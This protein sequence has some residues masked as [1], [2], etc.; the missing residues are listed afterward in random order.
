MALF[1]QPRKLLTSS[2]LPFEMSQRGDSGTNQTSSTANTEGTE[3]ITIRL[4]HDL[5]QRENH[6]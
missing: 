6:R 2:S 1:V 3:I 4:R 5:Q